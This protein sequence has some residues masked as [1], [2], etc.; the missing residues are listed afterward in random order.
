MER[1]L[2]QFGVT[3]PRLTSVFNGGRHESSYSH[4]SI[5]PVKNVDRM[6]SRFNEKTQPYAIVR[7]CIKQSTDNYYTP[8]GDKQKFTKTIRVI[9][10]TDMK[11]TT[12]EVLDVEKLFD[13]TNVVWC[14]NTDLVADLKGGLHASLASESQ[15]NWK[16]LLKMSYDATTDS[17][18]FE[19][20]ISKNNLRSLIIA[21]WFTR[22]QIKNIDPKIPLKISEN[23]LQFDKG[24]YEE[25][26]R[27]FPSSNFK[28][29]VLYGYQIDGM[30]GSVTPDP[31]DAK[32]I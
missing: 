24:F 19:Y 7:P 27:E 13:K 2:L 30:L 5:V 22:Y 18:E 12:F 1:V 20:V 23:F 31:P 6:T 32:I 17:I 11:V 25:F 8:L 28:T 26:V 3:V 21:K 29:D 14:Y 10:Q 4:T 16:P 9:D 15:K